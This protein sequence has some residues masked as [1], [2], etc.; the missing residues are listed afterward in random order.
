MKPV[1]STVCVGWVVV[2]ILPSREHLARSVNIFLTTLGRV[3]SVLLVSNRQS[4]GILV[5][6]L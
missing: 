2:V 6:I 1:I 3:K 5:N 4:P